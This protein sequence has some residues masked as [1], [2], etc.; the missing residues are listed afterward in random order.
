MAQKPVYGG[1]G[2]SACEPIHRLQRTSL[3]APGGVAGTRNIG[4]CRTIGLPPVEHPEGAPRKIPHVDFAQWERPLSSSVTSVRVELVE[5]RTERVFRGARACP[6]PPGAALATVEIH[7]A[8]VM[9][10]IWTIVSAVSTKRRGVRVDLVASGA[11][12]GLAV[13]TTDT[14]NNDQGQ[15]CPP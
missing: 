2:L 9:G 4:S 10:L 7:S 14:E 13:A 5:T 12:R 15:L 11:K 3:N 8:A 6:V 1:T